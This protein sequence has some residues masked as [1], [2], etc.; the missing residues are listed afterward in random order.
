MFTCPMIQV[1]LAFTVMA[2]GETTQYPQKNQVWGCQ[3]G[4]NRLQLKLGQAA[5]P[6]IHQDRNS[7][8]H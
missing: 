7:G 2:R 6:Y 3:N 1:G 8:K 5:G 4:M